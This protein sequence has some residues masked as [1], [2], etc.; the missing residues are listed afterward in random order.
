MNNH[1]TMFLRY[2]QIHIWNVLLCEKEIW[3]YLLKAIRGFRTKMGNFLAI[4]K[5]NLQNNFFLSKK[6]FAYLY[7]KYK[8]QTK[9]KFFS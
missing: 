5:E 6:D 9:K 1:S 3:K 2:S 4:K 7:E 8:K